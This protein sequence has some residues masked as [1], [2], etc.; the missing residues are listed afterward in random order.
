MFYSSQVRLM[1][2]QQLYKNAALAPLLPKCLHCCA[3][4]HTSG[5]NVAGYSQRN[6]LPPFV[7][8]EEAET[9][10]EVLSRSRPTYQRALKV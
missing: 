6:F 4:G 5:S 2:E 3:S 9:L 7:I 8:H 10:H 1:H